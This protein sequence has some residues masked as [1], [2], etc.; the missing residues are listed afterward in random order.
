M[1]S[2][3]ERNT[4]YQ[5][6]EDAI[7]DSGYEGKLKNK[8]QQMKRIVETKLLEDFCKYLQDH[9]YDI[10]LGEIL[11]KHIETFLNEREKN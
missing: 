1:P 6:F 5:G 3:E 9:Y 10:C 7:L 8:I 4:L 2:E 11:Q